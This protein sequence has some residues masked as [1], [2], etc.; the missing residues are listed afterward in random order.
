MALT[1]GVQKKERRKIPGW[2][3]TD[4]WRFE[5]GTSDSIGL[6]KIDSFIPASQNVSHF[7]LFIFCVI[8]IINMEREALT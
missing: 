5:L 6:G 1:L 3:R 8:R 2:I 7:S 4:S